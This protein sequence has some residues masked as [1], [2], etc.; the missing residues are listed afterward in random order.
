MSDWLKNVGGVSN[1]PNIQQ[2]RAA[3]MDEYINSIYNYKEPEESIS[4]GDAHFDRVQKIIL[5]KMMECP[6]VDEY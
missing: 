1:T 6:I 4:S 5:G 3:D 2:L